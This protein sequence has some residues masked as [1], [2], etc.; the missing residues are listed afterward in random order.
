MTFHQLVVALQEE[1]NAA[2][3]INALPML[4]A[5]TQISA[6]ML[7]QMASFVQLNLNLSSVVL[8]HAS[9]AISAMLMQQ[10]QLN[11]VPRSQKMLYARQIS[12]P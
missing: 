1:S 3:Q 9:T 8:S 2:I 5:T 12:S 10:V 6:A 4:L 7:S 11:A